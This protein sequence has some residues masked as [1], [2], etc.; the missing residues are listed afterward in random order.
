MKK[1][2]VVVLVAVMVLVLSVGVLAFQNEPD[3]FRGL[4][5]GDPPT[6]DMVFFMAVSNNDGYFLPEDKMQ[7]GDV[8]LSRVVYAFY[9]GER[10]IAALLYAKGEDNYDLLETICKG[11][12]GENDLEEG[13]YDLD[14]YGLNGF[15]SLSYDFEEEQAILILGSAVISVESMQAEQQKQ[16]EKAA[17][18]F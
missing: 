13:F 15:V 9:E 1:V 3:G 11:R 14:W 8:E 2:T 7:L 6:E 18:D 16:T 4:K 12:F 17:D 10:F 5:W